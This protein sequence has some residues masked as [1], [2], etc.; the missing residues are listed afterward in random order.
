MD[1]EGQLVG[2]YYMS[3][4]CVRRRCREVVAAMR[5]WLVKQCGVRQFRSP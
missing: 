1:I 4:M 5:T 2:A 3:D